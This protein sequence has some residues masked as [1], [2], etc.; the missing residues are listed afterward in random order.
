MPTTITRETRSY[1]DILDAS[2][3]NHNHQD[4]RNVSKETSNDSAARNCI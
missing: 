1:E 3:H 4:E 2:D